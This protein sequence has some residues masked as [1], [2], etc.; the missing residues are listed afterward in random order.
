ME[1]KLEENALE[2]VQEPEGKL[3]QLINYAKKMKL[4]WLP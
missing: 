2:K 1:A 4:K 3:D